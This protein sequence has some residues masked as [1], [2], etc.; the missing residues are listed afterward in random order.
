MSIFAIRSDEDRPRALDRIHGL[1]D[2]EQGT[3]AGAELEALATLVE[4]YERKK[5]P[6]CPP[7]PL[8]A[9]I[10]RMGQMGYTQADL[11]RLLKSLRQ[12]LPQHFQVVQPIIGL[13]LQVGQ[14]V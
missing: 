14:F 5:Y 9:I 10:F 13:F 8:D 1:M 6:R 7:A 4:G 12:P 3:P 2:A 11:P